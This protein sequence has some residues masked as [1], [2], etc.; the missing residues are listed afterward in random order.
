MR[1][2]HTAPAFVAFLSAFAVGAPGAMAADPVAVAVGD[3]ACGADT[4]SGTPCAHAKTSDVAVAQSPD[5]VLPLGDEQYEAGQL[6]NFTSFYEP[7]W[8]RLKAVTRPVLGNHEYQTTGAS[9]YFDYFNGTGNAAGPAGDRSK[10]Y[11]SFNVGSWHVVALNSNCTQV[12][13]TAGAAQETWLR[14][15]LAANTA[16]C[17][18]AYFHHPR[19]SSDT[20]DLGT[21]SV[22]P[23]VQALYAGGA[24][25]MLTGHAHDYERF[26]PQNPDGIMDSARGLTEIVVGTG[27]RSEVSFSATPNI[28]SLVRKTG[29]FGALRLDLRTGSYSFNFKPI[30]GQTWT[31]SGAGECH[32]AASS[33]QRVLSFAP[34]ADTYADATKPTV[35]YGRATTVKADASPQ[36]ASYLKFAVDGVGGA[37]VASAKLR[38]YATDASPS[39]GALSAVADSSWSESTLNWNNRPAAGAALGSIGTV[40]S[41]R[42]YETD[43]TSLV[44]GDG[45]VSLRISSASSDGVAYAAQENGA[46]TAPQ[47]IVTA[48]PG[49][50]TAPSVPSGLTAQAVSTSRVELNW[51]ASTDD[52]AVTSYRIRRNG[53]PISTTDTISYADTTATPGS[54][55]SY[56]VSALDAAGNESAESAPASVTTPTSAT[57]TATTTLTFPAVDDTYSQS[58]FP[59]SNFG[60]ETSVITDG[61]PQ[62]NVFLKFNVSGISGKPVTKTVVRLK[63]SNPTPMGGTFQKVAD[64]TWSQGSLTWNNQP[65]AEST[66]LGTLGATVLGETREVDVTGLVTGDGTV[67]VRISSDNA[68]GGGYSAVEGG[69]SPKLIVTTG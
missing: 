60:A 52:V 43:V 8:G 46:S 56:T 25:L 69:T 42:W 6:S 44:K 41:G 37:R 21:P 66:V 68:D 38:L 35:N 54:T 24:D 51:R 22:A 4:P 26:A 9:G 15:D 3:M 62:R 45:P 27:G 31:D 12:S 49:D 16:P 67:S 23:F 57:A 39:G 30:A 33:A 55:Y 19:W 11:Y 48:A 20:Y 53:T 14:A 47:L 5:V 1:R 58:D 17:T 65:S 13:C 34:S 63:V 32:K 2:I 28:N 59:A 10:G 7:T 40:T 29:T 50:T 64:T 61:S 36:R 18:L